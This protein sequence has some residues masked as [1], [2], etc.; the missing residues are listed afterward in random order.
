MLDLLATPVVNVANNNK[1]SVHMPHKKSY[2]SH[3]DIFCLE[4]LSKYD[5]DLR[6]IAGNS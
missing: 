5:F 1:S 2:H 4:L 6:L 3:T